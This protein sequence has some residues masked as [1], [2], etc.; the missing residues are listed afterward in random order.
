MA[1]VF[2]SAETD[3]PKWTVL[4]RASLITLPVALF[5]A[6]M[7]WL[8]F[9]T[10]IYD[11]YIFSFGSVSYF[12]YVG[13]VRFVEALRYTWSIIHTR[14]TVGLS[15]LAFALAAPFLF[16]LLSLW[17]LKGGRALSRK[18]LYLLHV[19]SMFSLIT[20]TALV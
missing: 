18:I 15:L 20:H 14:N 1:S 16:L 5:C 6:V 19:R 3:R 12:D 10:L 2:T 17:M 8:I 11:A 7:L 13:Q 9:F 4:Q